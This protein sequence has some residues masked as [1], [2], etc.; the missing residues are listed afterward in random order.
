MQSLD[1]L[2]GVAAA[3]FGV[4]SDGQAAG[5]F[6]GVLPFLQGVPFGTAIWVPAMVCRSKSRYRARKTRAVRLSGSGWVGGVTGSGPV[7][8]V[9]LCGAVLMRCRR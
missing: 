2:A 8:G 9:L 6:G 1:L 4:G 3:Q 5:L 7:N